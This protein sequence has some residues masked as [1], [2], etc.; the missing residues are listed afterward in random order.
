M[1]LQDYSSFT[2][3]GPCS[4]MGRSHVRK[5][6]THRRKRMIHTARNVTREWMG[7]LPLLPD[8][9]TTMIRTLQLVLV[10]VL[11]AEAIWEVLRGDTSP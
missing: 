1:T 3:N 7:R 4:G 11:V 9:L 6:N 10:A 5:K 8:I 2:Q